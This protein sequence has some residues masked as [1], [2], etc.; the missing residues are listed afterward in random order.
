MVLPQLAEILM[1]LIER[2]ALI[3]KMKS[4]SREFLKITTL[5]TAVLLNQEIIVYQ[6]VT[7][8]STEQLKTRHCLV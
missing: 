4:F 8:K 2:Q 7:M 1:R 6:P 5:D 3:G